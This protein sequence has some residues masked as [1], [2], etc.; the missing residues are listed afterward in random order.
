MTD[1][2]VRRFVKDYNQTQRASVRTSYGIL[3]SIVGIG[4]NLFLFLAK[5]MIG[6]FLNSISVMSDAFNNLSDAASSIISFIGVKMAGR[7]ADKDHPFGHG[8]IEYISALIVSFLVIEVGWTFMKTSFAKVRSPEALSFNMVSL[9]ILVLSI[10]VKLWMSFF[11]RKLGKRIGSKV[12]EATAA[13][14][15]GDVLVTAATIFS[16]ALYGAFGWNIDGFIGMAV[17]VV[18]IVAGINIAKD[19]LKPLIGEAIDPYVYRKIKTFV[20]G[21]DGIWG[22][23]DLIVHNY[24]PSTSM[25]SIHAEVDSHGNMEDIHEII[26]QIEREAK[27]QLGIFLVIHMDPIE[28]NDPLVEER[29]RMV[30]ECLDDLD[31]RIT[32]HDFRMVDGRKQVNLIFDI[33]VPYEMKEKEIEEVTAHLEEK[34]RL[35]DGRFHCV[36]T[37]DKSYIAEN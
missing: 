15:L 25:A 11:N 21:Y 26:D 20:E 31:G 16:V 4:C 19:T 36:I 13:D 30:L 14:S 9:I 22:T 8:R 6:I 28:T 5:L 12:M 17:S 10:G 33:V 7:P 37:V 24:G 1:F 23:H 27:E 35:L 29:R 18:V 2:L 34:L 32:L 3:S